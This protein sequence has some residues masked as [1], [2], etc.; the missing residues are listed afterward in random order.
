MNKSEKELED[1][2]FLEESKFAKYIIVAGFINQSVN[3]SIN[4]Y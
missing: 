2:R 3:Q 4:Q 1:Q